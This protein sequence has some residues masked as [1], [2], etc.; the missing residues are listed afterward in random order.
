MNPLP[1]GPFG[2]EE[3]EQL[4]SSCMENFKRVDGETWIDSGGALG[5]MKTSEIQS[6]IMVGCD[7]IS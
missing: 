6:M 4:K 5:K 3:I 2:Q 7:P 1:F